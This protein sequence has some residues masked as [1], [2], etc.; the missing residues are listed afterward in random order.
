MFSI[1][2]MIESVLLL[3]GSAATSRFRGDTF[4]MTSHF[5]D[6]VNGLG[7]TFQVTVSVLKVDNFAS[8]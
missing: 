8:N 1:P 3:T 6:Y 2:E 5:F 7:W 4:R